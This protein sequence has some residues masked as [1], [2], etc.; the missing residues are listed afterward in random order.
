MQ[1]STINYEH[2]KVR[3]NRYHNI[4]KQLIKD[5]K[6]IYFLNIFAKFKH[7]IKRTWSIINESLYRKKKPISS[8]IFYHN[9]KTIEDPNKIANAFNVYFI[10]IG[11]SLLNQF[12]KNNNFPKYF[13]MLLRRERPAIS[14]VA[15]YIKGHSWW[16]LMVAYLT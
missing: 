13:E 1:T 4:L 12:D 15:I 2:L 10:S 8:R 16:S 6:R 5:A 3:F 11:P 7:D 14:F 9:G